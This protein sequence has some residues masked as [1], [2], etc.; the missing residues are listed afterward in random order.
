MK[1]QKQNSL[2]KRYKKRYFSKRIC[3]LAPIEGTGHLDKTAHTAKAFNSLC[4]ADLAH[5][6]DV[7]DRKVF[8]RAHL[9]ILV[10]R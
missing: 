7:S 9:K 5:V 3:T 4:P 10:P 2:R 1:K 8:E 6:A